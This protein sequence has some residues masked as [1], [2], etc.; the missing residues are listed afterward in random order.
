L[1]MF[2][3]VSLLKTVGTCMLVILPISLA[4]SAGYIM[5]GHMDMAVFIQ[6]FLGLVIGSFVG[7]KFTSLA[8]RPILQ[9]VVTATP[10]VGGLVI[11]LS[12]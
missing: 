9:A 3:G 11:F 5:N 2:F 1:M 12:R 10:F 7:A 6:T 4:G 8:P